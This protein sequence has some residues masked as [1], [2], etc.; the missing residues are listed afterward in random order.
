MKLVAI[1]AES[2]F[3]NA[4]YTGVKHIIDVVLPTV[5]VAINRIVNI[6]CLQPGVVF[7]LQCVRIE[8]TEHGHVIGR[9]N[10]PAN[11]I[12]D[13]HKI[14]PFCIK[15]SGAPTDVKTELHNSEGEA[16]NVILQDVQP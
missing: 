12:D 3:N 5:D 14:A 11:S 15:K 2:R 16:F 8:I 10:I 13:L 1:T 4:N 7:E 6:A 9:N